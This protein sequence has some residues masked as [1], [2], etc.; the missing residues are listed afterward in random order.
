MSTKTLYI[1]IALN[2]IISIK[3][4]LFTQKT[5]KNKQIINFNSFLNESLKL[6]FVCKIYFVLLILYFLFKISNHDI[7]VFI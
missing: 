4:L 5:Y 2:D 1:K 3:N 7:I 6:P